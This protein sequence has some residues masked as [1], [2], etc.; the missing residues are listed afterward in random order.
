MPDLAV[1]PNVTNGAILGRW[2]SKEVE[3]NWPVAALAAQAVAARSYALSAWQWQGD[4]A[5][6]LQAEAAA[7]MAYAGH[8]ISAEMHPNLKQALGLTR[9][10]VLWWRDQAV[11]AFFHAASGGRSEVPHAVWPDRTP[12]VK[13]LAAIM[14]ARDDPWAQAGVAVAPKRLGPWRSRIHLDEITRRLRAGGWK[15]PPV[16]EVRIKRR[17]M[18]SNR[19]IEVEVRWPEG[20]RVVNA[21]DFRLMMG[22]G[23]TFALYCG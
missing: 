17:S 2:V 11:T 12:D 18:A 14:P 22:G 10:E 16:H 5:W 4:R 13:P 15:V 20:S 21:N 6:C 1:V 3:P 19:V 8:I 9:G 23:E 7:D